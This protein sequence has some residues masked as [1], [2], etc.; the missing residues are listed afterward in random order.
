MCARLFISLHHLNFHFSLSTNMFIPQHLIRM[1]SVSK[2][3]QS[4]FSSSCYLFL[5]FPP[6]PDRDITTTYTSDSLV[7]S[8]PFYH[9][10]LSYLLYRPTLSMKLFPFY[11]RPLSAQYPPH[12]IKAISFCILELRSVRGKQGD[13]GDRCRK[14]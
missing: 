6:S 10:V 9:R 1:F 5:F 2:G 14:D 7:T 3:R 8:S 12:G 13:R 4:S 11:F